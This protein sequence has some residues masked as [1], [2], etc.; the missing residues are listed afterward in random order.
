MVACAEPRTMY[1]DSDGSA[2]PTR[3]RC[4][5]CV[6]TFQTGCGRCAMCR[7]SKAAQWK[8]RMV[9]ESYQHR[10]SIAATLTYAPEH[11]DALG[12]IRKVDFVRWLDRLRHRLAYEDEGPIR[13]TGIAEYSPRLQRPH[14]HFCIFG[15]WPK[16]AEYYSQS[17]SGNPQY[18]S[19]ML[20]ETW[21][22][23]LVTFQRFTPGAAAYIAGHDSEK[24]NGMVSHAARAVFGPDGE[25]VGHR[26][27]EFL[28]ASRR[29][30]IGA[31][32][33]DEHGEQMLAHDFTV[34][35]G[36]RVPLPQYYMRRGELVNPERVAELKAQHM[37]TAIKRRADSTRARL[38]VREE[39][40]RARV[41]AKRRDG[42]ER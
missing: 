30:G 19:Q 7:A 22:K 1:R 23:G 39:C 36:K 3:H 17:K 31:G 10:Y 35:D 8:T 24:L 9:H 5:V 18:V 25:Y 28:M 26:E 41:A 33:F 37:Q 38:A 12:S 4:R 42:V 29:P 15:W 6:G 11:M 2:Y 13:H 27:P 21:G 16:D 32:F 14:G 40:A 20:T 34:V